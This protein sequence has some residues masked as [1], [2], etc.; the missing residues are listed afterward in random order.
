[1]RLRNNPRVQNTREGLLNHPETLGL[2]I[3]CSSYH[4]D[5]YNSRWADVWGQTVCDLQM[6]SHTGSL[7][8]MWFAYVKLLMP[9]SS[10][11]V[12]V[13]D[14]FRLNVLLCCFS[15]AP[16]D[17]HYRLSFTEDE[18][19]LCV[20]GSLSWVAH[21]TRLSWSSLNR[22]TNTLCTGLNTNQ[23]SAQLY[24]HNMTRFRAK[25]RDISCSLSFALKLR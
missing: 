9:G 12:R 2:L 20:I 24:C 6:N 21:L 22:D 13:G 1:M 8:S 10:V 16:R 14:F 18:E 3:L 25:H 4:N 7:L 11:N 23:L 19:L 5:Q 17:S 15:S